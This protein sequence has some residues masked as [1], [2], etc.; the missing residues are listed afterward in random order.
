MK[1]FL[2]LDKFK[3]L[4]LRLT[5]PATGPK[6]EAPA[7][8]DYL[9]PQLDQQLKD[10]ICAFHRD[11][12]CQTCVL[13]ASCPYPPLGGGQTKPT[14]PFVLRHPTPRRGQQAWDL[15]TFGSGWEYAAYMLKSLPSVA[16]KKLVEESKITF[17]LPKTANQTLT[18]SSVAT[19]PLLALLDRFQPAFIDIPPASVITAAHLTLAPETT[20]EASDHLEITFKTP[21]YLCAHQLNGRQPLQFQQLVKSLVH[22]QISLIR[23]YSGQSLLPPGAQFYRPAAQVKA[24]QVELS[25]QPHP[26]IDGCWGFSGRIVYAGPWSFYAPILALGQYTHVGWQAAFGYGWLQPRPA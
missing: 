26:E 4:H 19:A 6:D 17:L 24:V 23:Q 18:F 13:A 12:P 15:I 25:Q 3:L 9:Q 11:T 1:T 20:Y 22:R 10:I 21:T 2:A 16:T 5:V 7:T 8:T 14:L